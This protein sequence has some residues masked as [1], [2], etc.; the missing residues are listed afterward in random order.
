MADLQLTHIEG[1]VTVR[2]IKELLHDL[3]TEVNDQYRS[4]LKRIEPHRQG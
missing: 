2:E 3:P 1:A 4:Y